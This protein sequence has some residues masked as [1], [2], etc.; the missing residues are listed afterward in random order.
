MKPIRLELSAFGSY[1]GR[2]VIDFQTL[3]ARGLY[4]VSGPTGAG[5]TT[6]FD[7]MC[8][9]LYGV[10]PRKERNEVRSDFVDDT[11]RTTVS[12][13]FE[14]GKRRFRVERNPEQLRPAKR[15]SRHVTEPASATLVEFDRTSS[16]TRATKANEVSKEVE[17]LIGLNAQQFQRVVLL[18]QGDFAQ[19][20]LATSAEREE[21]LARLFGGEVY[22][23]MVDRLKEIRDEHK[24]QLGD[25]LTRLEGELDQ[26][27]R[28]VVAAHES[29]RP[30]TAV[31]EVEDWA[32]DRL[33]TELAPLQLAI[34]DQ[35]KRILQL[36][37]TLRGAREE[38]AAAKELHKRSQ[39]LERHKLALQSLIDKKAAVVSRADAANVSQ[40]ARSILGLAAKAKDATT[41]WQGTT[42][43]LANRTGN[44]SRAFTSL[45]QSCDDLSANTLARDFYQTKQNLDRQ[46]QILNVQRQA[47]DE[48]KRCQN[49]LAKV[50][51]DENEQQKHHQTLETQRLTASTE[52]EHLRDKAENPSELERL[53]GLAQE[54]LEAKK[55][56]DLTLGHLVKAN[57][58]VEEAEGQ[59]TRIF[60]A[61]V[62]S[63]APRLAAS[64][65]DDHPC[66]VCGST[67]H[68]TP[69]TAQGDQ[70]IS[71][72]EVE[73]ARKQTERLQ[74]ERTQITLQLREYSTNLGEAQ[75]SSQQEL[76]QVVSS[77]QS[78][79]VDAEN[80]HQKMAVLEHQLGQLDEQLAQLDRE[81]AGLAERVK[82]AEDNLANAQNAAGAADTAAVAIDEAELE[83]HANI[84]VQV[85]RDL[86]GLDR[87]ERDETVQ[88]ERAAAAQN[89]L[90][91]ALQISPFANLSEAEAAVL[92]ETTEA[93]WLADSIEHQQLLTRTEGFIEEL[94]REDIPENL[95]DLSTLAEAVAAYELEREPEHKR[96]VQG[97]LHYKALQAALQRYS[98]LSSTNAALQVDY[99]EANRVYEVCARGGSVLAVPLKRWVL[100]A[101]LDRVTQAANVQLYEMTAGRYSL[102]RRVDRTDGRRSF[103]LDIEVFD[104][105][106]GK[107][108]STSSLSGG[109]AFQASL[110]LALGLADVVSRGGRSS[111]HD[112][113]AL[114]IDEGFGSLSEEAL[115]DAVATLY[116]LQNSGRMVG[117]ISHVESMKQDLH[118]GI[119]VR[120]RPD[121]HGSTLVI[122]P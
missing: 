62:D 32:Y 61:F 18:P 110:A 80:S 24:A 95:P 30:N 45:G 92:P 19:F 64:L 41:L 48:L 122:N 55:N 12:F 1:P 109:E 117:V 46:S 83:A 96:Q 85:E 114:F 118:V 10:M 49:N 22:D 66:P 50:L 53:L 60:Q 97:E 78:R 89:D 15:G 71:F 28:A 56:Y 57:A 43:L 21:L 99:E 104:A 2:E 14:V 5:K 27:R 102:S 108:R 74:A 29:L 42:E 67:S 121:G 17:E 93:Q 26:A 39:D 9:A 77:L 25:Q 31:P 76:S 36:D 101:E 90:S 52:Y 51:S 44:L 79:V 8:W 111:G 40:Q 59:T 94:Q 65:R 88:G 16:V 47:H 70:V 115:S 38:L 100:A 75:N 73:A 82:Q 58:R 69:A 107:A 106:T 84:L 72:E 54:K 35:T 116:Q 3:Y 23:N 98:R 119:E 7:A 4:L 33:E 86:E 68:P 112:F 34:D 37:E 6:I 105:N 81:K 87:L 13:D 91:E 20:L 103:G 120:L 113:E 63:Q 11:T